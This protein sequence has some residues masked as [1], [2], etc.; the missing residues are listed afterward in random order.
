IDIM[1]M[2]ED[3][4]NE[5]LFNIFEHFDAY[6]LHFTFGQLNYRFNSL[7]A[8][9]RVHFDLD[10]IPLNEFASFA[11]SLNANHILSFNSRTLEK[12]R[13]WLFD[14]NEVLQQFSK[15][16]ALT[17]LNVSYGIIN[18]LHERLPSLKS[19]LIYVKIAGT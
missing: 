17:L 4:S 9:A 15:I 11:L 8:N 6:Q 7:L 5:L 3:L 12:T 18:R 19:I 16:R 2:F 1:A 10:P 13:S 14:N